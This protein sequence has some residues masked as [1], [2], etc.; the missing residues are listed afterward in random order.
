L[1]V[2][3]AQ[4]ALIV[5]RVLEQAYAV[6]MRGVTPP[7]LCLWKITTA[8]HGWLLMVCVTLTPHGVSRQ[9][10]WHPA[11]VVWYTLKDAADRGRL[12]ASTFRQLNLAM[13]VLAALQLWGLWQ[14][15]YLVRPPLPDCPVWLAYTNRCFQS[16]RVCV[17]NVTDLLT[18][19]EVWSWQFSLDMQWKVP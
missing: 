14:M 19:S 18:E 2:L 4:S 9:C 3:V 16:G 15:V 8:S 5:S 7:K 13:A 10:Q 6:C 11:G 17:L 12:G 1:H